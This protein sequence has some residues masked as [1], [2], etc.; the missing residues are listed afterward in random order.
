MKQM[1]KIAWI[2][3]LASGLSV[4]AFA[5]AEHKGF[6]PSPE[7]RKEFL[8]K[9]IAKLPGEAQNL[10]RELAPLRDSLFQAMGSYHRQVKDGAPPRSLTAQRALITSL[11][12]RIHK[13]Q[14][15]NQEAWLDL[16]ASMPMHRGGPKMDKHRMRPGEDG[17]ECPLQ[18]PGPGGLDDLPPPPPPI[19]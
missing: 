5:A 11:E 14:S 7:Q 4:A 9:R 15:E 17:P 2:A 13:L 1:T 3:V 16:L 19:P 8:E 12:A 6:R 18:H 10:A